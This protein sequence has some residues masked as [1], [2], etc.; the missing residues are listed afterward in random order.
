MKSSKE[1]RTAGSNRETDEASRKAVKLPPIKK[2]G[3]DKHVFYSSLEEDDETLTGYK[4]RESVLD[5][6]D[7][8]DQDEEIDEDE[9]VEEEAYEDEDE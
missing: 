2:N 1:I 3:K 9:F 8:V 5:Y 6:F 7:D 4:K